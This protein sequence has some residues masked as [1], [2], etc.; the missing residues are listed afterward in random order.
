[1]AKVRVNIYDKA[2]VPTLGRGPFMDKFIHEEL[3]RSLKRLGY[4]VEKVDEPVSD[5]L[6]FET[7][8]DETTVSPEPPQVDDAETTDQQPSVED[9]G[10]DDTQNSNSDVPKEDEVEEPTVDTTE[11]PKEDTVETQEDVEAEKATEN[12]V[13]LTDEEVK[14]L[15]GKAKRAEIIDLLTEKG[16]AI[17]D[18]NATIAELLD[19]VGLKR[20]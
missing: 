16:V 14:F 3:F 19:L 13:E 9:G 8:K 2:Y 5:R 11:T 7:P 4:V 17:E 15:T 10:A 20:N 18:E 6:V 1:M 12:K